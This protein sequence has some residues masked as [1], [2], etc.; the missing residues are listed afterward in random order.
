MRTPDDIRK[1]D[2]LLFNIDKD[3]FM[4]GSIKLGTG[5]Y[6]NFIAGRNEDGYEHVSVSTMTS[7]LPTWEEMSIVKDIFW[8]DEEMVV[9]LHPK[10]SMYVNIAEVLHLWRPADGDWSI[11][12]KE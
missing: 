7:K 12:N 2:R 1:D 6:L 5:Y 3:E 10:K 8:D 11:L 4:I 9:Q